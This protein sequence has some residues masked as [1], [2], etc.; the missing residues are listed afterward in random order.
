MSLTDLIPA[1]YRLL[2]AGVVAAALIAVAVAATWFVQGLRLDIERG[3]T[4]AAAKEAAGLAED[5]KSSEQ[6]VQLQAGVL[7][8]QQTL[9]G[10]LARI[11]RRMQQ[12]GQTITRNDAAQSAVLQ[13]LIRNDQT[14][15]DYFGL[16]V[17]AAVGL[18]Y[19]RP[20]TTD[21]ASYTAPSGVQ[22]GAVRAPGAAGPSAK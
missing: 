5:L 17:P 6:M 9:L 12:L 19:A 10:D 15:A 8:Q 14:V 20:Q 16:P 1:Q 4:A 7:A 21:P 22:P 18:L 11:D 3:H 13:E 2:A